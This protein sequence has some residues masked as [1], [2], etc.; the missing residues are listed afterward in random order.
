MTKAIRTDDVKR[1]CARERRRRST[2]TNHHGISLVEL[3]FSGLVERLPSILSRPV[4][5]AVIICSQMASIRAAASA[6]VRF[7]SAVRKLSKEGVEALRPQ[8]VVAGETLEDQYWQSP[9][10]SKRVAN[11][12]RKQ[13]IREGSYGA[14]NVETGSGWDPQWDVELAKIKPK[15]GGR[16]NIRV[17]KK[18]GRQRTREQRAQKVERNMDGMDEKIEQHYAAIHDAK[19]PR[20]FDTEY[21]KLMRGTR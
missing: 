18:T 1:T 15:G 21:K 6:T 8:L 16:I 4:H 12:L 2:S 17:P 20:N 7:R 9:A 10:I 13:A 14:F 3:Q 5:Q 19:P 11:S